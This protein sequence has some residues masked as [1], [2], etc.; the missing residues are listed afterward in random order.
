MDFFLIAGGLVGLYFGAEWLLGGAVRI[1]ARLGLPHLIVSLVI[2]GFGTSMPELLVSL[3]AAFA[4]A[5]DLA[6]GNV[7]GSNTAN[8]LLIIGVSAAI[9]PMR[10]WDSNVRHDAIVM[11]LA[12]LLVLVAVQFEYIGRLTGLIMLILLGAYL[13]HAYR[14]GRDAPNE[15][16]ID[17]ESA[18]QRMWLS[19]VMVVA[20]LA[21]L[22]GGAEMLIRGAT[23]IARDYGVSEAVIGL[24]VVALGTSLP[25]LATSVIAAL[26]RHSDIAIGNIV[27][28]C[29]FNVLC[30]LGITAVIQPIGVA[31]QFATFDAPVMLAATIAFAALLIFAKEIGRKAAYAMLAGYAVYIALLV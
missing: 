31:S 3:R 14:R 17:I 30:I 20:G 18:G 25:E 16:E 2:V 29:I 28:S 9:F 19:V 5:P 24:T 21:L 22:F 6:L 7:I 8:I 26:K 27:G 15:S 23:S 4:G 1:A 12:A 11:V 13:F 10:Q